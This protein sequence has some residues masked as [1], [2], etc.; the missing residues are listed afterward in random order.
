MLLKVFTSSVQHQVDRDT[1][2][3]GRY[4]C[5][6]GAVFFNLVKHFLFDVEIFH[7]HFNDPVSVFNIIHIITEIP[8]ADTVGKIRMIQRGRLAFNGG[9]E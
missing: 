2:C 5:A 8:G 9:V 6:R 1:R 7:N 4:K 3:I